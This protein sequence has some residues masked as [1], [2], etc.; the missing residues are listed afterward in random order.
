MPKNVARFERLMY[1][2]LAIGI[3]AGLLTSFREP[4]PAPLIEKALAWLPHMVSVAFVATL[5][6]L[7]SRRRKN[8]ARWLL[9]MQFIMLLL[10]LSW[11][12]P[13]FGARQMGGFS[14]WGAYEIVLLLA[15]AV[16]EALA[17]ALAF[18][19][20]APA[21]FAV[22]PTTVPVGARAILGQVFL[23]LLS[24]VAGLALLALPVFTFVGVMACDYKC[25]WLTPAS[26]ILM[27][28]ALCAGAIIGWARRTRSGLGRLLIVSLAP[29]AIDCGAFVLGIAMP[30]LLPA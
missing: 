13:L 25:S 14:H 5:I 3:V 24:L 6:W 30:H 17:L 11:M 26:L 27:P 7:A 9:L 16:P 12:L 4:T 29:P 1:L 23:V 2:S 28:P 19:G 18:S 15:T 22:Q 8:W 21:W 10:P 20:D